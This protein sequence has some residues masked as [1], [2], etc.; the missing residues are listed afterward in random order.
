MQAHQALVALR[1]ARVQAGV[2]DGDGQ[3]GV[4]AELTQV[5]RRVFT[6]AELGDAA[7]RTCR[8]AFGK[9]RPQRALAAQL[10]GQ[11]PIHLGVTGEQHR[12]GTGFAQQFARGGRV[13]GP[14][15]HGLPGVIE[16]YADPTHA[17]G[18]QQEAGQRVGGRVVAH[19][20][21]RRWVRGDAS[22]RHNAGHV[23]QGNITMGAPMAILKTGMAA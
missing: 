16:L 13:F 1:F 12:G 22:A 17:G 3:Q 21:S 7:Y 5:A 10:D 6:F 18:G 2:L 11:P 9:Q 20:D 14:S 4:L 19:V 8:G 23:S 15:R